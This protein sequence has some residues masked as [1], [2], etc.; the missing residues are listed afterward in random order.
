MPA[1]ARS[2]AASSSRSEDA[3][4]S[5][6][7]VKSWDVTSGLCPDG[8][9][10]ACIALS[11]KSQRAESC[12]SKIEEAVND[13]GTAV[14]DADDHPDR[15]DVGALHHRPRHGARA[16]GRHG[17]SVAQ[18]QTAISLGAAALF[19]AHQC[20]RKPRSFSR[21]WCSSSMRRGHSTE[22]T[23]IAC[24]VYFWSRLAHAI[25]YT[26]GVPVLRTLCLFR[27]VSGAS[28]LVLAV[29]GKL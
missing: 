9:A 23:V 20:G 26:M 17:Q 4:G 8:L 29:F 22:G 18:R 2:A 16:D 21:H 1:R 5:Y 11:D 27:R 13:Q 6:V 14:A 19:R 28:G 12:A 15:P 10:A 3:P 7:K 25:V 24:A